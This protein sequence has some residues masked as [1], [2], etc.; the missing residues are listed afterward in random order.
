MV[1][2]KISQDRSMAK[3]TP[4]T[5]LRRNRQDL[6]R[7]AASGSAQSRCALPPQVLLVSLCGLPISLTPR[8]CGVGKSSLHRNLFLS[9]HF[10]F[11]LSCL[12]VF[13]GLLFLIFSCSLICRFAEYAAH[14]ILPLPQLRA[15]SFVQLA[16]TAGTKRSSCS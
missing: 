3:K 5:N 15:V 2:T 14:L 4:Q 9:T 1:G 6:R 12:R 10:I 11:F 13:S 7:L 16:S 8:E